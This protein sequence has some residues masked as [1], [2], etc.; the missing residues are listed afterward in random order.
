MSTVFSKGMN[1][2]PPS[3]KKEKDTMSEEHHSHDFNLKLSHS[4]TTDN[5]SCR[6][7]QRLLEIIRSRGKYV[8]KIKPDQYIKVQIG[9]GSMDTAVPT[10][11]PCFL[12]EDGELVILYASK[13]EVEQVKE[14][15]PLLR[16]ED[17]CVFYIETKPGLN[18]KTKTL[19]K[20]HGIKDFRKLCVYGVKGM[21]FSEALNNDG[22]FSDNLGEFKLAN[23]EKDQQHIG[24][25]EVIDRHNGKIFQICYDLGNKCPPKKAARS[26]KPPPTLEVFPATEVLQNAE[27]ENK[28]EEVQEIKDKLR[29]MNP[30]LREIMRE[31]YP[32]NTFQDA[33]KKVDFG[34]AQHSFSD[35][36]RLGKLLKLG[37]SVCKLI[38]GDK[39]VGTAFVLF[40][41]YIL[42]NAHLIFE[43]GHMVR[44][45]KIYAQFNYLTARPKSTFSVTVKTIVDSDSN[46]DYAILE[47]DPEG[48]RVP[49]GLM[50]LFSPIPESGEACIIG[51]PGGEV[52]KL[53]TTC[54]IRKEHRVAAVEQH[55]LSRFKDN[56]LALSRI[57]D[58]LNNQGIGRILMS[59]K[60]L[61]YDTCMYHGAS[62]SPLFNAE[63]QVV[64]LHSA[65]FVY[66][67][68][69]EG[70]VIEMA[71]PVIDIFKNFV[72]NLQGATALLEDI[73]EASVGNSH[74]KEILDG[75]EPMDV[76]E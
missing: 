55:V 43:D 13:E 60:V 39:K 51:H 29:Q 68:P 74:L 42:T 70:S 40:K 56:K 67:Y 27:K 35:C 23:I 46:L 37:K 64:A 76:D 24:C 45:V 17:Y 41:N 5:I 73:R 71:H 9:E 38:V 63:C 31:Q 25:D 20:S 32:D 59:D 12:L 14:R 16:K 36:H 66:D 19:F 34:K 57:E 62:G 58:Q 3:V 11:F 22:R 26:E 4:K 54:I 21:T 15:D 49:D 50:K 28:V 8:T 72:S 33:L 10:H 44:G 75:P 47:L 2:Y 6:S 30:D 61:T 1:T 52:R 18:A 7:P 53:D 69:V 48:K 65:G